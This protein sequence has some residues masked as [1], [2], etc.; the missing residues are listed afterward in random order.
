MCKEKIT[1]ALVFRGA[2]SA[3]EKEKIVER[4]GTYYFLKGVFTARFIV[5]VKPHGLHS[6]FDVKR[7]QS[8][9]FSSE[10]E[11]REFINRT[12]ARERRG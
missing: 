1:V 11:T 8:Y 7:V 12:A 6:L 9:C 10:G 4:W 5:T 3:R 2:F